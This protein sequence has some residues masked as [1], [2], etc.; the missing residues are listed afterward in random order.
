M[1]ERNKGYFDFDI[2]FKVGNRERWGTE[3]ER[4]RN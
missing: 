2:E 1:S 4:N 3:V